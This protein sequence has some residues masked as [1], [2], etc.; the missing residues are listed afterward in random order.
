MCAFV[1]GRDFAFFD[2]AQSSCMATCSG[3]QIVIAP[4]STNAWTVNGLSSDFVGL[5]SS[6]SVVMRP[7]IVLQNRMDLPLPISYPRKVGGGTRRSNN[8]TEQVPEAPCPRAA[9]TPSPSPKGRGEKRLAGRS[10]YFS[11]FR[12]P[13]NWPAEPSFVFLWTM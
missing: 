1:G 12:T 2:L 3:M 7:M 9:L 8:A 5:E 11:V 4:V 10:N 6:I 13:S